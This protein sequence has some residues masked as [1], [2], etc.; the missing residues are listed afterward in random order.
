MFLYAIIF[1]RVV[2]FFWGG[3]MDSFYKGK[4]VLV[5]GHTG[6]K[7]SWL[8]SMLVKMGA[9]VMGYALA[10]A[11]EPN[12]YSM[13]NLPIRSVIADIRDYSSLKDAFESFKPEIVF[14]LAAQPIVRI[15]YKEPRLTYETNMMGTLNVCECIRLSGCVKSF[16]NVTT[17]K[18]Y[19]E[20]ELVE[21][22]KEDMPIDGFDPYS[23]SKSCSELITHSYTRSYFENLGISAST[24]RAGNVIGGGDFA[25]DRIMSDCVRAAIKGE[26]IIVRNPNS[27]RP[28]QYVLEPLFAYLL[29]AQKQ[30]FY[31]SYQ[32]SYNVGP[33]KLG[34]VFTG[35]LCD[36]FCECYGEGLCWKDISER[37]APHETRFLRLNSSKFRDTFDWKPVTDVRFAVAE[38]VKWTKAYINGENMSLVTGNMIDEYFSLRGMGE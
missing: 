2:I 30:Y 5:T 17:D 4:R 23:N 21:A 15:G 1:D 33:L 7:G 36:L 10:P 9:E 28:Y 18:V 6:F 8:C 16:V 19:T 13:L 3:D 31:P 26:D 34:E 38:T 22:Y 20:N 32:G 11:S 37:D 12:L 25:P 27:T 35:E 29:L 24:V 14:H